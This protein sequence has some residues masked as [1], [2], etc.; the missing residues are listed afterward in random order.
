M[1][2]LTVIEIGAYEALC[3]E[4]SVL[5]A[6]DELR[7]VSRQLMLNVM[8][9]LVKKKRAAVEATDAGPRYYPIVRAL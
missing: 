9:A 5:I 3:R 1:R 8:N 7:P 4:G 2:K 6:D